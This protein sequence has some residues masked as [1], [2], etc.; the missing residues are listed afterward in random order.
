VSI[1]AVVAVCERDDGSILLLD[2]GWSAQECCHPGDIGLLQRVLGV[3]V[4]PGDDVASQLRRAG[5][6]PARVTTIVATHLH[7]DH[8][9]GAVDFPNAELVATHDEATEAYRASWM[10]AYRKEDLERVRRLRLVRLS[11]VPRLG[12]SHSCELDHEVTL[13]DARGHTAG[14]A[15]V[16]VR[17]GSTLWIHGGDTA[18]SRRELDTGVLC[19]LSRFMARD[20]ASA[21][22]AQRRL[23]RSEAAHADVRVVLSHDGRGFAELPKLGE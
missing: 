3:K 11:P 20:R 1:P 10:N 19:P 16:A 6:D 18:Y 9:G 2:A 21:R 12:F 17:Q 23:K 15:A 8:V 5:L 22:V 14:H 7:L 4:R 13:L